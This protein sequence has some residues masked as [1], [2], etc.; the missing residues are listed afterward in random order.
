MS[1][2]FPT[3]TPSNNG[4]PTA[5][6]QPGVLNGIV[7][8]K[9]TRHQKPKLTVQDVTSPDVIDKALQI[10]RRYAYKASKSEVDQ[11]EL[12]DGLLKRMQSWAAQISP[13]YTLGEF[14]V[15]AKALSGNRQLR[16]MLADI[17]L[18]EMR[19]TAAKDRG[20]TLDTEDVDL[21]LEK[22]NDQI[23]IR[24]MD[25]NNPDIVV[26]AEDPPDI[27]DVDD[28]WGD[29]EDEILM[30]AEEE[31]GE[32]GKQDVKQDMKQDMKQNV[33]QDVKQDLKQGEVNDDVDMEI[34]A[35]FEAEEQSEDNQD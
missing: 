28:A 35:E 13:Q 14:T 33:K 16:P 10:G 18:G 15:A 8:K 2:L 34:M 19:R 30:R 27:D 7:R 3:N 5:N 22:Q 6:T 32:V 12:L 23:E 26:Q 20:V 1:L 24:D 9:S 17:R 4:Q 29:L 31:Q 11:L 21:G 25:M